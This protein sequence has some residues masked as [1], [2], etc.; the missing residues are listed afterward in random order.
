MA[1]IGPYLAACALLVVAGAAKAARPADT[2]RALGQLAGGE[3]WPLARLSLLVRVGALAEAAL[4]L[5]AGLL[6]SAP[7]AGTVA[8]SYAVF[9]AFV[10]VARARGGPLATC[11]CFGTPDTPP[12]ALHAA[13]DGGLGAAAVVTAVGAGA[14]ART[15]VTVLSGEPWHGVPLLLAAAACAWLAGLCLAGMGR[16]SAVRRLYRQGAS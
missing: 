15:V 1:L 11:G 6:V 10:L 14:G 2:A 3:H 5:A 9:A 7:L 8:G 12:T 13:V 4:G 16:L